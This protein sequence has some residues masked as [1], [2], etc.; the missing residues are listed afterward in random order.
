MP[1]DNVDKLS[2]EED[3]LTFAI[4]LKLECDQLRDDNAQ[5]KKE[6]DQAAKSRDKAKQEATQLRERNE[7]L[8]EKLELAKRN[9]KQAKHLAQQELQKQAA[10]AAKASTKKRQGNLPSE[11]ESMETHPHHKSEDR[12]IIVYLARDQVHVSQPQEHYLFSSWPL[13]ETDKHDLKFSEL[14]T[15][16][17]NSGYGNFA[18]WAAQD[19]ASRWRRENNCQRV[20]DLDLPHKIEKKL[21]EHELV[22]VSEISA[23]LED[24]S[25]AELKGI[26]PNTLQSISRALEG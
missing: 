20:E 3:P 13:N 26:G 23:A 24:G 1:L 21:A 9:A 18:E 14:I 6:R 22:L 11:T 19:L 16:V 8:S 4:G 15:G 17:K 2:P 25:L 12:E 7:R 10:K 5:L